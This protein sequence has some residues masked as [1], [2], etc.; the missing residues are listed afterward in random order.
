MYFVLHHVIMSYVIIGHHQ[1]LHL[2]PSIATVTTYMH[3]DFPRLA[4]RPSKAMLTSSGIL[5]KGGTDSRQLTA[6]RGMMRSNL[7][8][9]LNS[10]P[11]MDEL[12]RRGLLG[13]GKDSDEGTAGGGADSASN[14]SPTM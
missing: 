7:H 2:H 12:K 5:L 11:G 4:R 3:M 1:E 6:E 13:T 14:H 9:K 8:R 10:R